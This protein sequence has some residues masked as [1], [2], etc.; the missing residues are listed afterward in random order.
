[1]NGSEV[2]T[3]KHDRCREVEQRS[4]QEK[5]LERGCLWCG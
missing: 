4:G 5:I 1:M 2:G 3:G